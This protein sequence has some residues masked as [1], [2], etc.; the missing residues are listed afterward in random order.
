MSLFVSL[1]FF[2]CFYTAA[3]LAWIVLRYRYL[4]IKP[5]ILVI[6]FFHLLIQW[7]GTLNALYIW[8]YLPNPWA[9][10]MLLHGFPIIG[11]TISFVTWQKDAKLVFARITKKNERFSLKI[12]N[13]IILVLFIVVT[14]IT[15]SYLQYVPLQETGLWTILTDPKNSAQ[16]RENSLKLL[17]NLFIKY[18][19]SFMSSAF[20]PLLAVLIFAKVRKVRRSLTI[21]SAS[22]I[23]LY[24]VLLLALFLSVSFTGAR[25]P[26]AYIIL[27]LFF[28]MMLERGIPLNPVHI[29]AAFVLVLSIPAL[30]SILRE[31]RE[32][33][34]FLAWQYLTTAITRRL[35]Y[36]P[37]LTGLW[38]THLAQTQ[39][40]I[41]IAGIPKL[42]SFL[43]VE[44]VNLA[45]VVGLEYAKSTIQSVSSNT[46]YVFSYYSYFGLW[47]FPISI[48]GLALLDVA[49]PVYK[50]LSDRILLPCVASIAI[51]SSRF[52]SSDYTTVLATHG[53]III[54]V[55]SLCLDYLGKVSLVKQNSRYKETWEKLRT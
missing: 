27:I 26:A 47:S 42:A 12:D 5:S 1:N 8:N 28:S 17:E 6:V 16:A 24:Y 54:L 44:P 41:G 49:I 30:L 7:A 20:A 13:K 53:F 35:F 3:A 19:Y 14:I 38:H 18:S 43:G 11:L 23:L 32:A 31:G 45:N 25:T 22:R 50:K 55:T 10:A 36:V 34:V 15:I 2:F 39:G 40:F 37:M 46:C 51:A 4:L 52:T 48:A 29:L 21:Q 33:N 9:F